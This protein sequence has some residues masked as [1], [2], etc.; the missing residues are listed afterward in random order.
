MCYSNEIFIV[1]EQI[2]DVKINTFTFTLNNERLFCSYLYYYTEVSDEDKRNKVKPFYFLNMQEK[3]FYRRCICLTSAYPYYTQYNILLSTLYSNYIQNGKYPSINQIKYLINS[4]KFDE[5]N[6]SLDL[7]FTLNIQNSNHINTV[8]LLFKQSSNFYSDNTIQDVLSLII[9]IDIKNICLIIQSI[10]L[11]KKIIFTGSNPELVSKAVNAISYLISPFKWDNIIVS[12]ICYN[13][14][15]LLE[16]PVPFIIGWDY[17]ILSS[18]CKNLHK[19]K[20]YT[21]DSNLFKN[22]LTKDDYLIINLSTG[23]LEILNYSLDELDYDYINEIESKVNSKELKLTY[24]KLLAKKNTYVKEIDSLS[25]VYQ[26]LSNDEEIFILAIVNMFFKSILKITNICEVIKKLNYETYKLLG[27]KELTINVKH[28][29]TFISKFKD[30]NLCSSIERIF[31]DSDVFLLK[32]MTTFIK[33]NY[34]LSTS[35]E[36]FKDS[37]ILSSVLAINNDSSNNNHDEEEIPKNDDEMNNSFVNDKLYTTYNISSSLMSINNNSENKNYSKDSFFS[38]FNLWILA[39]SEV[40]HFKPICNEIGLEDELFNKLGLNIINS[41]VYLVSYLKNKKKIKISTSTLKK[42]II[43]SKISKTYSKSLKNKLCKENLIENEDDIC[44]LINSETFKE[45]MSFVIKDHKELEVYKNEDH[46]NNHINEV[47]FLNP[48]LSCL[49]KSKEIIKKN[50][51]ELLIGWSKLDSKCY[52]HLCN[53]LIEPKIFL[54]NNETQ[55]LVEVNLL[56]PIELNT[57]I[58]SQLS[59]WSF[60]SHKENS[61]YLQNM[62]FYF[63]LFNLP[64]I[65]YYVSEF[66]FHK[67]NNLKAPVLSLS[68]VNQNFYRSLSQF[69]ILYNMRQHNVKISKIIQSSFEWKIKDL[70]GKLEKKKNEKSKEELNEEEVKQLKTEIKKL[71]H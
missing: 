6:E 1:K 4:I 48:C 58:S 27:Y 16:A 66:L 31:I 12:N 59:I 2:N 71:I 19:H 9:S 69:R 51:I 10:L 44:S 29:S 53:S 60:L 28:K 17:N 11:E 5:E 64:N 67:Y 61:I 56:S 20:S 15:V 38:I 26:K 3:Y 18:Y 21:D 25:Y 41:I 24:K 65:F 55:D 36:G 45:I 39:S 34:S 54:L 57:K 30:T 35:L 33:S 22:T 68:N 50:F 23:E 7:K 62:C 14:L 37:S 40:L 42:V 43:G 32:R 70:L 47:L 49:S 52:C 8:D 46:K 63:S 13:Q